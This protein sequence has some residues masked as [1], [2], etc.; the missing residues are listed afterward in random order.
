M[1]E[2]RLVRN[3]IELPFDVPKTEDINGE[4]VNWSDATPEEKQCAIRSMDQKLRELINN[5]IVGESTISE[6]EQGKL[7]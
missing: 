1:I 2:A 3:I 4:Y 7:E 6:D 5:E